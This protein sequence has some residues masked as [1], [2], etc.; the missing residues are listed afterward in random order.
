MDKEEILKLCDKLEEYG[1]SYMID[2]GD[3]FIYKETGKESQMYYYGSG[4][5]QI[6]GKTSRDMFGIWIDGKTEEMLN[7]AA[8]LGKLK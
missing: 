7:K 6:E 1:S 8:I 5:K 2:G 3:T 4:A